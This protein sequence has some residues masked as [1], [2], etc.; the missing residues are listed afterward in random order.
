MLI[1]TGGFNDTHDRLAST[2]SLGID[3]GS[4]AKKNRTNG[5]DY[6]D[7]NAETVV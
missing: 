4:M 5:S 3:L 6:G 1:K 7:D 2:L